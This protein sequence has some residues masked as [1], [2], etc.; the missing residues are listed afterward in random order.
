MRRK[1][2]RERTNTNT[3]EVAKGRRHMKE[4]ENVGEPGSRERLGVLVRLGNLLLGRGRTA[5]SLDS[6][7]VK[8]IIPQVR[9][10]GLSE[11][12][13]SLFLSFNIH[14]LSAVIYSNFF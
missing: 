3:R 5:C 12:V 4:T 7:H 8:G 2:E 1:K 9:C 6:Q 10:K 13:S 14:E 11:D